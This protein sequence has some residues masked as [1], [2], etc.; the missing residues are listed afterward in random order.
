[1][2]GLRG[3]VQQALAELEMLQATVTAKQEELARVVAAAEE[4]ATELQ[5]L[6]HALSAEKEASEGLR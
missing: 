6:Q 4:Q 3:G 5:F 2:A 1:M